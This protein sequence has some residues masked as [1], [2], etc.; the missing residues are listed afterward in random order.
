MKKQFEIEMYKDMV[1]GQKVSKYGLEHGYLDYYTMSK[2]V[3]SCI[4]N[5][6]I[7]DRT[8][9]DWELVNGEPY[10]AVYQDFIISPE[11]YEFLKEFTDE[12]VYYNDYL[13]VYIWCIDHYGTSWDHVLT[14]L[15]LVE[16]TF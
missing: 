7:M 1:F 14:N 8:R 2:I 6:T 12:I 3:G 5:N 4:L 9:D 10:S 16:V 11:G 13:N 15:K